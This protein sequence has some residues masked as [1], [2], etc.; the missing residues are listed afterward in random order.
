MLFDKS[1][2]GPQIRRHNVNAQGSS[3]YSNINHSTIG[4]MP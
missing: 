3:G 4:S 2:D 1:A